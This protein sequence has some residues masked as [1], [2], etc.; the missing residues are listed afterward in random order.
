MLLEYCCRKCEQ[1]WNYWSSLSERPYCKHCGETDVIVATD[2]LA[3]DEG[4]GGEDE[5]D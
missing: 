4:L 3:I 2:E 1:G 5:D